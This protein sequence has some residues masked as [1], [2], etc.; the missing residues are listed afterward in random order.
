MKYYFYKIVFILIGLAVLGGIVFSFYKFSKNG[1]ITPPIGVALEQDVVKESLPEVATPEIKKVDS[2]TNTFTHTKYNFSFNYPSNLKTSNFSEG[3]GEQVLFQGK[4]VWFQVYITSWD[5][6]GG[7]TATRIKKDLP[8]ITIVSPQQ[9]ILGPRQKDGIGPKAIIFFSK[10]SSL[11]ETREIWFVE[12]GNLYQITT[13]KRL[14]TMIGQVL[15]TLVF[16]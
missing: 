5:E 16:N 1:G 14:D 6:E 7:I 13:Y 8:N 11:G 2:E 3:G 10:D 15:S 4:D 9:V 12:N